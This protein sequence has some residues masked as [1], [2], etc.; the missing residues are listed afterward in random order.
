MEIRYFAKFDNQNE[1]ITLISGPAEQPDMVEISKEEYD[2]LEEI[3]NER[4]FGTKEEQAQRQLLAEFR[5][6]RERQ[7]RAFDIYKSNIEYGIIEETLSTH[8]TILEWYDVMLNY[9]EG[10]VQEPFPETPAEVAKY[11]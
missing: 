5:S 2:R 11:L 8:E 10:G 3:I 6:F 4:I 7:F 9:P 1:P